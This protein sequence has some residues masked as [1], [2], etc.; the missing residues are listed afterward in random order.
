MLV[1]RTWSIYW[2]HTLKESWLFLLQKP[3][4]VHSSTAGIGLMNPFLSVLECWLTRS[5]AVNY[6]CCEFE[7]SSPVMSRR[8]DFALILPDLW[9]LQSLCFLLCSGPWALERECY[10]DVSFVAEPSTV[11]CFVFLCHSSFTAQRNF[12]EIWE[13]HWSLGREM[14]VRRS[15]WYCLFSKTIVR[16]STLGPTNTQAWALGQL[17]SSRH[18]FPSVE[19]A[20]NSVIKQLATT[21]MFMSLL[22]VGLSHHVSHGLCGIRSQNPGIHGC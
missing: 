21:L 19:Q 7:F 1:W 14:W 6:R 8:H 17:C 12:S 18:E 3:Y 5:C 15:V 9:L 10:V 11:T 4:P 22:S 13:L 2:S 16:V 20:L